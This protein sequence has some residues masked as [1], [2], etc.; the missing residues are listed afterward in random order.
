MGEHSGRPPLPAVSAA[1]DLQSESEQAAIDFT[2]DVFLGGAVQ[3][4]QPRHGYRAGLDAV[5]LAASVDTGEVGP[6]LDC[7]AGAGVVG[8]CV[9]ARCKDARVMLVEREPELVALAKRNIETNGFEGR[10]EVLALDIARVGAAESERL[11]PGTYGVVLANPPYYDDGAGTPATAAL[12]AVSHAMPA[13][14]LDEWAR[15]MARMC[16][17]GGRVIIIHKADA[18]GRILTAF[19]GRFGEVRIYPLYPRHG[20]PA[21]RIIVSGRKGSR[22]PLVLCRGMVLHGQGNAFTPEANTILRAGA[23]LVIS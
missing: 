6:V 15:F 8:L 1:D 5:M 2:T 23:P 11:R 10:A 4:A 17:P 18:L 20:D 19:N 9:A 12:K 13:D 16:R 14:Q 3:I 7:G 21:H 22:A